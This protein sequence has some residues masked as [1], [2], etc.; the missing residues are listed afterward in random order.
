[1]GKPWEKYQTA[2][3]APAAKAG[4]WEKYQGGSSFDPRTET[5]WKVNPVVAMAAM[6]QPRVRQLY[7]DERD[8]ALKEM[9]AHPEGVM[10]ATP[11]PRLIERTTV[12]PLAPP[13]SLALDRPMPKGQVYGVLKRDAKPR[14]IGAPIDMSRPSIA[15]DDG[16]FS[17]ERTIT[18]QRGGKW[19]NVP[20]IINGKQYDPQQVGRAFESG[21]P[22]IP[23]VG[24]FATLPEADEAVQVRTFEIGRQRTA[25]PAGDHP[26]M[27]SPEQRTQMF[28][29][30][31]KRD[32]GAYNSDWRNQFKLHV[33]DPANKFLNEQ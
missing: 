9:Q 24:E 15:N 25:G 3:S 10:D 12:D 11:D 14:G 21:D 8:S 5:G 22:S 23:H 2:P 28:A 6:Q 26:P 20:T 17:T 4:P 32:L 7:G 27:M 19:Y 31:D 33:A 29:A 18:V 1:M 16:S 30:E 13:G